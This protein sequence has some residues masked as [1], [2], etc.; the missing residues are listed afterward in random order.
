MRLKVL[1]ILSLVLLTGCTSALTSSEELN[2]EKSIDFFEQELSWTDCESGF[3]CASFEAPVNWLDQ[4]GESIT[5]ALARQA[6]SESL[7]PILLNPGG[8]G[9]SG[10]DFLIN[11][12]QSLGTS[13]LRENFQLVA[14]DPRGVGRSNPVACEPEDTKDRLLYEHVDLPFGSPEYIEFTDQI[15]RDFAASCSAGGISTG[16]LNTQQAARDMDL[17]R[18]LLGQDQLNY[19]GF[20]YGT[21]L[22]ATYAALFPERVGRF[23]LDGAVDPTMDPTTS[24]LGQMKGFDKALDAYL[25][26]CLSQNFCPFDGD[27]EAAKAKISSFLSARESRPLPA[28][29]DRELSLQSAIAGIIVTLYAKESWQYLTQAFE[30]AFAGN[31]S[32]F[33]LLADFYND[34][35]ESGGYSSNITEANYAIACADGSTYEDLPDLTS[36]IAAASSVF[37][38]YFAA[39]DNSCSYWPKAL[40][41]QELDFTVPLA[42][43][44]LVVGTTGDPATPYEQAVALSQLLSEAFLV[45]FEG[46]GHT[47]YGGNS[48]VNSLVDDFFAGTDPSLEQ[49]LCR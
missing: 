47:A 20:S 33:L 19:L 17:I 48:C 49:T 40:G 2:P 8:P 7:T 1:G 5:I 24:L 26:D 13:F 27:V 36:E 35:N 10:I 39:E 44:V 22:G 18:A 14:F 30:E 6:E 15:F 37:G 28:F 32:T 41:V 23:V 21:E 29:N 46:E 34:R 42:N 9:S 12:Y 25:E 31:G 11:G 43:P 38:K 45:T 3:E 16:Y 4:D